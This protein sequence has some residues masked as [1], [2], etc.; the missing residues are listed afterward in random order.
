MEVTQS[1]TQ[2]P[3][4]MRW[5]YLASAFVGDIYGIFVRFIAFRLQAHIFSVMSVGFIFCM[6]FALGCIAV[7]V[8]ELNQPRRIWA[9]LWLPWLSVVVAL[10][11]ICVFAW[12]GSICIVMFLPIALI[13]SS[14]GGLLG[15]VAARYMRSRRRQRAAIMCV[16]A[17][18]FL[19]TPWEN[20]VFQKWETRRVENV[21][22]IQSPPD[23]VWRNI[24]RVPAIHPDE[25]PSSWAHTIGFPDPIE[26]TL[27]YEGIGGVRHAT[28]A[29]NLVFLETIDTWEPQQRLGF[30]IAADNIPPTTLD[31]HVAIGGP[32]FD[33]LR[34][35]YRLERLSNNVTRLHLS[36]QHRLSTDFNWYAHFWTDG[37]MS[38][39]Q[40]RILY[41]IKQ[42][43]Q[44][45]SH[46]AVSA[47]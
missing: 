47:K 28:F 21:I 31:E 45:E 1:S 13:W 22:D 16:M 14:L 26:A 24:E 3:M 2:K 19:V 18:P 15:G 32:Y 40:G 20:Q 46:L 7:Y 35:E 44:S 34:G 33:V 27:S 6:P 43:C 29:K 23:I 30:T 25:L 37:V 38:D 11:A 8:V 4:S 42:R 10:A 12:E 39:L 9:W 17:L 5:L 41:V 36:S